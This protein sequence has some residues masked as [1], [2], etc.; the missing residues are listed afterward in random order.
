MKKLIVNADDFGLTQSITDGIIKAFTEGIVRSASFIVNTDAFGYSVER[1]KK[2]PG[3]DLGIHI[4]WVGEDGP[5]AEGVNSLL[6]GKNFYKNWRIFTFKKLFGEIKEYDV[7]KE[8]RSQVEKL[9]K[10]GIKPSHIDSHQHLHLM[11]GFSE[12]VVK[13]AREYRIPFVRCTVAKSGLKRVFAFP[14]NF[15]SVRLRKIILEEKMPEPPE[16]RGFEFSGRFTLLELE[17]ALKNSGDKVVELFVH[18][19]YENKALRKKYNWGY[20][21]ENEL[22]ELTSN[23][24]QSILK[25]NKVRLTS[26][27]ELIE[28]IKF[29]QE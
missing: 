16:S 24:A 25:K 21:W 7:E 4:S 29:S 13:I 9:L 20:N 18:P 6:N 28:E 12:I 1:A 26:F 5:V 22:K 19:G 23:E 3:L 11:P 27:R 10:A 14:L 15:L 8:A 17:R 2:F